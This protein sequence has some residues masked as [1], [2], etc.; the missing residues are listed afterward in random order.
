MDQ[1]FGRLDGLTPEPGHVALVLLAVGAALTL[2]LSQRKILHPMRVV[3]ARPATTG[4]LVGLACLLVIVFSGGTSVP[5]IYF[6]F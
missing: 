5:F 4:A 6:Q 3:A 2:D 1:G